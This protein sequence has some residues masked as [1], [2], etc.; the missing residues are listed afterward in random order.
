MKFF[1]SDD[2]YPME[3]IMF[4]SLDEAIAHAKKLEQQ[5]PEFGSWMLNYNIGTYLGGGNIGQWFHTIPAGGQ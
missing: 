4:D 1:V 5:R 3:D 2:A